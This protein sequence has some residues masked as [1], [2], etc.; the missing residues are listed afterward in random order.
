MN[1]FILPFAAIWISVPDAPIFE[2][3][4]VDPPMVKRSSKFW[5]N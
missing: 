2:G 3:L 4:A 5:Y 1:A